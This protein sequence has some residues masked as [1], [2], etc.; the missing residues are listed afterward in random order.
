LHGGSEM[1]IGEQINEDEI[2]ESFLHAFDT[3]MEIK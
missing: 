1:V 2:D 3:N